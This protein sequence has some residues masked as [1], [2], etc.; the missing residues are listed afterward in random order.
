MDAKEMA[1]MMGAAQPINA[2][3][4]G[5]AL[6]EFRRTSDAEKFIYGFK[7]L[8]ELCNMHQISY[9]SWKAFGHNIPIVTSF[10]CIDGTSVNIATLLN[11][12]GF[13]IELK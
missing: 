11:S 4:L 8:C 3:S 5:I 10:R 1:N 9:S 12:C 7:Q 2:A 13:N 6:P